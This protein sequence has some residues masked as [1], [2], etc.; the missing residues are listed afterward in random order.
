MEIMM[1]RFP[2]VLFLGNGM[3]KLDNAG[4]SWNELLRRIKTLPGEKKVDILPMAMQPEALC[5]VNVEDIQ[6]KIA[7]EMTSLDRVN[8]LF[9]KLL[10]FP[11]DAIMTT[12]YTY[13]IEEMLSGNKWTEYRRK[14]SLNILYGSH[15]VNHNTFA[16]N[17]VKTKEGRIVPVFHIHGELSRKHSM[18]LSYYSYANSLARLV[19]YNKI[20]GNQLYEHQIANE[21]ILCRCWL[22]YFI[23]GD[24]VSVGFG[25]DLSEFDIWWALERKARE[26]AK[27][28]KFVAY[29]EKKGAEETAQKLLLDAMD[30]ECRYVYCRDNDYAELYKEIIQECEKMFG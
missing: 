10:D 16:C 12:N 28:G 25:L 6:R 13:E 26:I 7:D 29:I 19:E 5:G 17:V 20:L 30:A 11:F 4:V 22:D 18:I 3:L 14:K 1:N 2:K 9:H 15:N 24:V 23:M 21:N 27:H 8:P